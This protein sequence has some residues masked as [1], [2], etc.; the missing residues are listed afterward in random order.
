LGPNPEEFTVST[1]INART[2]IRLLLLLFIAAV[3]PALIAQGTAVT[4]TFAPVAG[5]YSSEQTVTL[6]TTTSGASIYYTTDGNIPTTSSTLYSSPVS[7]SASMTL[8][9]IAVKSGLTDS[10][11][12]TAAYALVVSTPMFSSP[13]PGTY[14]STQTVDISTLTSGASMRY[15]TNGSTPSDTV[16]TLYTGLIYITETTTLKTIA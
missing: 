16:G 2:V 5:T 9:A 13:G 4:P 15:T 6:G 14:T 7:V 1:L 11:V 3:A 8:K 10:S 12:G